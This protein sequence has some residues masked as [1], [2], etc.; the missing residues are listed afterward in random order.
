MATKTEEYLRILAEGGDAPTDCCMTNTQAL[1]AE[2]ID[3]INNLQP[4]GGSEPYGIVIHTSLSTPSPIELSSEESGGVLTDAVL[5]GVT[6]E[7][8]VQYIQDSATI[9]DRNA[10]SL[11]VFI[12]DNDAENVDTSTN[13]TASVF[14]RYSG[15]DDPET[16]DPITEYGILFVAYDST[17]GRFKEY[18][19]V[20]TESDGVWSITV[21]EASFGYD[22]ADN[23]EF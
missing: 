17:N 1:I 21:S 9:F 16:G 10:P 19:G 18:E 13:T 22:N 20:F 5:S 6:V 3:R 11:I 2:A 8:F 4:G 23:M 12:Y 7:D 14:V 15:E